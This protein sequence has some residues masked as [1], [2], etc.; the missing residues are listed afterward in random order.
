MNGFTLDATHATFTP[1]TLQLV[2][3][4]AYHTL[5]DHMSQASCT[6]MC[7]HAHASCTCN[8][9]TSFTLFHSCTCIHTHILMCILIINVLCIVVVRCT[10]YYVLVLSLPGVH[11]R[12]TI[13]HVRIKC[14]CIART[15]TSRARNTSRK[16]RLKP[17]GTF[18]SVHQ[19]IAHLRN[20]A[21][22][23]G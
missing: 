12:T 4:I 17:A 15:R 20:T 14:I 1:P 11:V 9:I 10:T 22:S 5:H 21:I 8:C 3:R 13:L 23:K 18:K 16:T 7:A 19:S 6:C 2:H